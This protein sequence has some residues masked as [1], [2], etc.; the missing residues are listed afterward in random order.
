MGIL[1]KVG[2]WGLEKHRPSRPSPQLVEMDERIL[3]SSEKIIPD[4]LV[5]TS[6]KSDLKSLKAIFSDLPAFINKYMSRDLKGPHSVILFYLIKF[7]EFILLIINF[8]LLLIL[9][10]LIILYIIFKIGP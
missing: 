4:P 7:S 8:N 3:G 10:F 5:S 6:L 1:T 9:I 2:F